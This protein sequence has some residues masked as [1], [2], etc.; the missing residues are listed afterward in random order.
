MSAA[1]AFRKLEALAQPD[2]LRQV[3]GRLNSGMREGDTA[4]DIT[5][6]FASAVAVAKTL[7]NQQ[8]VEGPFATMVTGGKVLV[9]Q[10]QTNVQTSE[11][12][13]HLDKNCLVLISLAFKKSGTG[14]GDHHFAAF[15]LDKNTVVAAMGWQNKYDL[16]QWFF[17]NQQGKFPRDRFKRLM[18]QIENGS[19]NAVA[20]LCSF[21]G[22][23]KDGRSIPEAIH[24]EVD[25]YRAESQ[26]QAFTL[27]ST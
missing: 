18:E 20:E 16:T 3:M 14:G 8:I 4:A 23:T 12:M 1:V 27:P 11:I 21:L 10:G 9:R 17:E 25:G 2:K 5:S 24:Q 26:A 22:A 6:C 15:A 7:T 19:G 13:K